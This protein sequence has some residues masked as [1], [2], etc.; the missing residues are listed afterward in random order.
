MHQLHCRGTSTEKRH[1]GSGSM[2]TC[3]V[4]SDV[5]T[6]V[7]STDVLS[8]NVTLHRQ[9]QLW[10]RLSCRASLLTTRR[11]SAHCQVTALTC[12]AEP[13]SA[14]LGC[15]AHAHPITCRRLHASCGCT[16]HWCACR[17]AG[18]HRVLRYATVQ[19]GWALNARRKLNS[20]LS[21]CRRREVRDVL[22]RRAAAVALQGRQAP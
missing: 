15:C 21:A 13:S 20:M 3:K 19:C 14:W 4:T 11:R 7:F 2:Q 16:S 22:G 9:T 6:D 12:E 8:C 1:Q 18:C 10:R 5:T 17:S